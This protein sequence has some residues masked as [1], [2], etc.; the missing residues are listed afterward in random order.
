LGGTLPTSP[1]VIIHEPHL[2]ELP[3][4]SSFASW[5]ERNR[6]RSQQAPYIQITLPE[7]WWKTPVPP[8]NVVK[9]L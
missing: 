9:I 3:P 7:N 4:G 2:E 1:E 8:P 6:D 5:S